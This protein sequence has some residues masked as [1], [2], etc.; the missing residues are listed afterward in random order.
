MF[1]NLVVYFSNSLKIM[2]LDKEIIFNSAFF[3]GLH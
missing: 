2:G 1:N 3:K